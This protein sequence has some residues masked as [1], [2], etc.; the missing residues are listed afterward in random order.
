M[1]SLRHY[2]SSKSSQADAD[3]GAI[4]IVLTGC[5]HPSQ[6]LNGWV[7]IA[8]R[9][10][11]LVYAELLRYNTIASPLLPSH[12]EKEEKPQSRFN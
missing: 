8:V 3:Q 1:E 12:R 11:R 6:P 5:F 10:S 7:R 9:D 2:N 4:Y